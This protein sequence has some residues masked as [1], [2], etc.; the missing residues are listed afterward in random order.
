[1]E[2]YKKY[3]V[4]EEDLGPKYKCNKCGWIYDPKKEGK[5]F[6]DQP[7][8]YKCPECGYPKSQFSKI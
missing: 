2:V 1:M 3:L 7:S 8:G 6:A 4:S 5:A